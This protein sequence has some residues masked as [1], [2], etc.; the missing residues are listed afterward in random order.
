VVVGWLEP[1]RRE[2]DAAPVPVTFVF[3][4]DDAGWDD[5][6]LL[7]LLELFRGYAVP[8]DLAVIPA[9]LTRGVAADLHLRALVA[10]NLLGL[11]QH[12]YAHTNHERAGRPC[13]FGPSRSAE[14]QKRDIESGARRLR[15]LLGEIVAPIFTPPWNR[16]ARSTGRTLCELRFAALSR[17]S[18][19]ESLKI[20]GLQEIGVNVDW[21]ARRKGTRVSLRE[22]GDR[23]AAAARADDSVGVML[24]H[25]LMGPTEREAVE[26]L[27]E[28]VASNPMARCRTMASLVSA[29][30]LDRSPTVEAR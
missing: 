22:V 25:A 14:A 10:P 2:L 21:L 28:V 12:G 8:L 15:E 16:C 9:A 27:L 17:D 5:D 24:H 4:D 30:R 23:L 19:A 3:R 6:G 20:P 1:L 13:E 26:A 29:G 7:A 18:S 11:H